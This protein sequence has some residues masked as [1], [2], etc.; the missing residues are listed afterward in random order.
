LGNANDFGAG[1]AVE[2][3]LN[4]RIALYTALDF[5]L[6]GL[7]L[8]THGRRALLLGNDH[9]PS[10]AG[11]PGQFPLQIVH[12]RFRRSGLKRNFE[13]AVFATHQPHVALERH[14]G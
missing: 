1:E 10:L 4:K 7:G 12:Q 14:L 6:L 3:G 5:R 9:D 11:P 2:H 8:C 13:L